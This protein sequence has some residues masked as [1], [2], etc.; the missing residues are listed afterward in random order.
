MFMS[1]FN[2][3]TFKKSMIDELHVGLRGNVESYYKITF[4]YSL[5]FQPI[6]AI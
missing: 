3:S 6:T 2:Q 1:N 4:V 5:L